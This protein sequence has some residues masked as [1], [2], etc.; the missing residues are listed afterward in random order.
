MRVHNA[1]S[2]WYIPDRSVAALLS[3]REAWPVTDNR[4]AVHTSQAGQFRSNAVWGRHHFHSG[5]TLAAI[6]NT[7]PHAHDM[8][9]I[10]RPQKGDSSPLQGAS[11]T[12]AHTTHTMPP[13]PCTMSG[14]GIDRRLLL[15]FCLVRG[16]G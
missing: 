8:H 11:D 10:S 14:Q 9:N 1:C 6:G 15:F 2:P 5:V 7:G 16:T 13:Q 3:V 4:G 12:T